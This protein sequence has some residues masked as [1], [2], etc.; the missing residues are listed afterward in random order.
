[1][2]TDIRTRDVIN[3][4]NMVTLGADVDNVVDMATR[5]REVVAVGS[6]FIHDVTPPV[7]MT[8]FIGDVPVV[9]MNTCY[10]HVGHI[11]MCLLPCHA[12]YWRHTPRRQAPNKSA[13]TQ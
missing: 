12:P 1:M 10:N 4:I 11:F 9:V 8:A 7:A 2:A 6:S 5:E 13:N 3:Q